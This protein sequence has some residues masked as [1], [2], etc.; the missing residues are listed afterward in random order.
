VT[1]AREAWATTN[2]RFAL[3]SDEAADYVR[4]LLR[5]ERGTVVRFTVQYEAV[6]EGKVY[7]VVRYDSAHGTP[8]RDLLNWSG[9]VEEKLWLP[10]RSFGAVATEAVATIKSEWRSLRA[11]FLEKRP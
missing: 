8:H 1:D 9:R 11:A 4:V 7:P 2:Y 5:V 10:A 3:T 6:I